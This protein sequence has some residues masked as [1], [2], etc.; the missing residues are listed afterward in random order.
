MNAMQKN[1]RIALLVFAIFLMLP[2]SVLAAPEVPDNNIDEDEDGWLGTSRGFQVRASHPRVLLDSAELQSVIDRMYGANARDPYRRWFNLVKAAEDGG[3]NVDLANLALIYKATGSEIYKEKFISRLPASGTPSLTELI[4]VDIMFDELNDATKRSIMLRATSENGFYYSV[5]NQ[6]NA[7]DVTA[8]NWGYHSAF[9]V[10]PALAYAGIFALTEIENSKDPSVYTFNALNYLAVA[11]SE[12][13]PGGNFYNMERR[14]GG[15]PTFNDALPGS[16]GGMYDNFGYDTSEESHSINVIRIFETLTGKNI[17]DEFLHDKYR[18]DFFQNMQYPY[19]YT[20]YDS[21]QWCRRAGTESHIQA[22]IW[23]TQTD[24]IRQPR[25]DTVALLSKIYQDE[26]MQYYFNN[27]E[28]RELC[29]DAYDGMFWDLIFYDDGLE[30]NPPSTNPTAAYFNGPGLVSMRSDWTNN[31]A[32]GVFMAGEGISRR[33][34]DAN[35]FLLGRK[36]DVAVHGGAR[37]RFNSDNDKHHWYHIRSVSKNTMK[38]FDPDESFDVRQS[39]GTITSLHSG[40]KLV[41]SDNLGGQIFETQ[42]STTDGSYDRQ[43]AGRLNCSAYPLGVCEVANITKYEHNPDAG[44]TYSVGDGTASYTKK[45][46]FFEREFLFF[47]PDIFVI[48]DRI[49]SV[50][51]NFKKVWTMHTVDEPVASG[52]PSETGL[53]MSAYQ[54]TAS[55]SMYNPENITYIDSLLPK[56]NRVVI[57][58]GDS[59]LVD[60][61]PLNSAREISG[62]DISINQ[63]DIPR[64]L[65]FLGVGADANGSLTIHGDAQEGNGISETVNFNEKIQES[66]NG[67]PANMT[68]SSLT[69]TTQNWENDQWKNYAVRTHCSGSVYESIITGNSESTIYASFP[70]T[71]CWQYRIYKYVANSYNHWNKIERISTSD[72]N[73][74]YLTVSVPHYFD[75]VG[76]DGKVY[77]FSP[78]TD[79]VDDQ[80][81]KRKE[82]GQWT[83]EVE[84]TEPKMLDNFL[85]VIS[86]KDEEVLKPDIRLIESDMV[87][88]AVVD[89]RFAVFSNDRVNVQSAEF[90]IPKG[91]QF[92]GLF[93]DLVPDEDYYYR[94]QENI[95]YLST[96]DNGGNVI[97][98]SE[99][100]TASVTMTIS[101]DEVAPASPSGLNVS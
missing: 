15:D 96:A 40:T 36:T 12:L 5:I 73:F 34:E 42:I 41:P 27:G 64:W 78:H 90:R 18:G 21:N 93:L 17:A 54:N 95:V 72:L 86:L 25:Q 98:S 76:A 100:G 75:T 10:A 88:G 46:D 14:V 55:S 87:S 16:F 84:A 6:S 49:K 31:A 61:K 53:G 30:E 44:Y 8:P 94:I 99:M 35:S 52:T 67:K 74:D 81:G 79:G 71:N 3:T 91:G 57:R 47:R 89:S 50:N 28:W 80:Y 4:G 22:R 51:P 19:W 7:S 43:G 32:F 9:G 11:D 65:E 83:F 60:D 39:D 85:N 66:V 29:G 2:C 59:I 92:A 24:W 13:H 45:I 77:S 82:L 69:D 37:I 70:S 101:G 63:T 97:R 1:I 68:S 56:Q 62:S 26:R 48:F 20:R 58:G 23:N 33:Y 38:I